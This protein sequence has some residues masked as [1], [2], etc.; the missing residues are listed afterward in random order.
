MSD[1]NLLDGK[2][3]LI[4][5]D[6]PDVLQVLEE[7][8]TMCDVS[9]AGTFEAA[10]KLLESQRF[11]IAILDIMGVDG[12]RL[13]EIANRKKI[14][15]VMLTAHALTP[16]SLKRSI[17]EGAAFYIPKD[18]MTNIATFLNDV[19]EARKQGQ[20]TWSRWE[21]RLPSSFFEK[22]FGAAWRDTDKEFWDTFRASLKNRKA[23][24]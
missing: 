19:L 14:T 7:L 1:T 9:K 16:E 6:E 10:E 15:A 4:V 12:F 11:D 13:L 2:K 20:N 5:D 17:N 3:V 22:R 8:L 23:K 21:E 18:E 24:E